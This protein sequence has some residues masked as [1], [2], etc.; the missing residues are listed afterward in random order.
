ME[1]IEKYLPLLIPLILLQL[2]LL[3]A[4]LADLLRREPERIRG[5][6]RWPWVIAIVLVNI[7]G[8]LA[9]FVFGRKD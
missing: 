7:L 2:G 9:Y 8:P 4:A 5:G 1:L 3:I 6:A